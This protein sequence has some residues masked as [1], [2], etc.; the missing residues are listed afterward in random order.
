[1]SKQ[2]GAKRDRH[3]GTSLGAIEQSPQWR[4]RRAKARKAQEERWAARRP[5]GELTRS[6]QEPGS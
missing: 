3:Q 2:G 1:M 5:E 6:P 4:R